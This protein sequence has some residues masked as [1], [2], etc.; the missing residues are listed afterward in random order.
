MIRNYFITAFR[1]L[2]RHPSSTMINIGGLAAGI[3]ASLMI[4]LYV[5]NELST[6]RFNEDYGKIH[7]V[8]VGDFAVTG[9]APALLL[10]DNFPE[11]EHAARMDFRYRPLL[12]YGEDNFTLNE[13]AYADSSIFD[14]FSFHFLRGDP[15]SALSLPFS[16]V[17]TRSS[18]G[19]IFGDKD[20]VG[21][22]VIFDNNR[23]Y[24]VTGIIDDPVNFH[25]P[26]KGLGSFSTLPL[27]END[28]DHDRYLFNYMNFLTYV[29]L[30]ERADPADMAEK[31]N[32]FIDIRFP[33]TRFLSFRFRPLGDIYFNREL[34]DSP[35][36]RHG[37]MPLV[38]TLI[39]IAG[40][41]LL[42]AIV[43]FVNLSTAN[44]SA[45]R[46]EIGIR[47]VVGA[48]RMTLVL[49]FIA[50]SVLLS[51]IAFL[52]GIILV[53]L[54][55]PVFN[56]LLFTDLDFTPFTNA[57][58]LGSVFLL[59]VLT[60]ILAGIYPAFYLASLGTGAVVRG[61]G[62]GRYGSLR[63]RRAL[64][65]VQF[66]VSIV[67]ITGTVIVSRQVS[68]MRSKD[69]GFDKA[70]VILVR[71]NSDIYRSSDAF[72]ERLLRHEAIESVSMSNNYPGYVTWFN[73]WVIDGERKTHRYLP[74]D[75]EYFDLMGIELV[76]GRNF[77][78]GR[79]A[80]QEYTY[81]LNEEAVR[82]F[83]FDEP[84]GKEFMV[85]GPQPV[86]IIGVAGNF[87]FRSLHEPV[88]PLVIG[89]Q[90]RNLR[91]VNIRMTPGGSAGAI[92]HV[93]EIWEELSPGTPFEYF[94][95]DGE[96]DNLYISEIRMSSLF[97]YFALIAVII[98][99]M[100]LYG[101][102]IFVAGRRTREIAV[103]KV[104]GAGEYGIVFML[105]S[106]FARWVLVSIIFAWPLAWWVM[107]RWLE[108]FPYRIDPGIPVYVA[109]GMVALLI[110][111]ITVGGQALR[112]ARLNPADSLRDE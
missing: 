69:L 100:G 29:V 95:L 49:Q 42:V 51:F 40:L 91:M 56:N 18:A 108:N 13:F 65:V 63:F 93:R 62:N 87:H 4:M 83:G 22:T 66:T 30:D 23:Q 17:L 96:I 47:K 98:A 75:P 77:D 54:L 34:D 84:A 68:Y 94:F 5:F 43:N 105:T 61:G 36:V 80:D 78:P 26:L 97:G 99:C 33:D 8:E 45:R 79:L 81:I 10:R 59:V 73:T 41:I 52:L 67:L 9:T 25:L 86:R 92:E 48:D 28:D 107:S 16:L 111:A 102:S 71:A 15:S 46:G 2:I 82:Y 60:G 74:V 53:E 1:T 64:I 37:N 85:G 112:V 20:P 19:L 32:L 35:P 31:F 24:T 21:E 55:L 11:V 57:G 90:P 14:V 27:I 72:R 12:R 104:L 76:S 101:L 89:W 7:R 58:F 88:G 50:E 70:N 44:A 109:S 103:R 3:A 39:V 110:A 106:E 38:K 6:D